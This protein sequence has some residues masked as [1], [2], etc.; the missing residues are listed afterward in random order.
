MK[1]VVA[2]ASGRLGRQVCAAL[3][4]R[5]APVLALVRTKEAGLKLPPKTKFRAVD[6]S[7]LESLRS[8]LEGATHVINCTGLID[9]E[10]GEQALYEAN[11]LATRHLLQACPEN[12]GRFVHLSSI[13]VYGPPQEGQMLNE[14]SPRNPSG[15]YGK[16]K[17]AAEREVLEWAH[18]LPVV[19]LQPGMI[20]GPEFREGFWPM[21]RQLKKGN[22]RLIGEGDNIIPLVH[23]QDVVNGILRA[24]VSRVPSGSVFL[25][26]SDERVSQKQAMERAAKMLGKPGPEEKMGVGLAYGLAA[27]YGLL[28]KVQGRKPSL[29]PAMMLQ[30]SASRVFDT[31]RARKFLLWRPAISFKE[32]LSQVIRKFKTES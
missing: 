27:A 5:K 30:L 13:S 11:V 22:A 25:L 9:E 3:M 16:S 18:R 26:V 28:A 32:G 31:H 6:Y 4:A 15:A 10:A 21:L 12:L 17:L 23:I 20:Y 24:L 1:I 14:F 29:T 19:V 8:A 2:G 7:D